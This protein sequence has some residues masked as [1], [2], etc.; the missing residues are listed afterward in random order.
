MKD[1]NKDP[2]AQKALDELMCILLASDIMREQ[3]PDDGPV[4]T[5][6]LM[7]D[8]KEL[9]KV[10]MTFASLRSIGWLRTDQERDAALL[11]GEV[12]QAL[13]D[14]AIAYTNGSGAN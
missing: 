1:M 8:P 5:F 4:P 7:E 9:D 11:R 6:G 2:E 14:V 12:D 10:R 3:E 13:L